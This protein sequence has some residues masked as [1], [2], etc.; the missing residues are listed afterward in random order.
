MR[1]DAY[2]GLIA[3]TAGADWD[4]STPIESTYVAFSNLKPTNQRIRN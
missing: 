2:F 1:S 4:I 3:V